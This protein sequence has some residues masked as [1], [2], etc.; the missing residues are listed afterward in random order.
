MN[1]PRKEFREKNLVE[2]EKKLNELFPSGIPKTKTWT[3]QAEIIEVLNKLGK[4][5]SLNHTFLPTGGGLDLAGARISREPGC[6]ELDWGD[7][8]NIIKPLKLTFE[9]FDADLE[10]A[11][12]RIECRP[13]AP[14]GVYDSTVY[15]SEEL[16]EVR[17]K[18]Y[19]HRSEWDERNLGYDENGKEIPL[20]KGARVV[21]RNFSGAFV[22]FAKGSL[23]NQNSGTYDARHN[24]MTED[25][26]R[27][28]I[29]G[30]IQ[31]L[32]EQASK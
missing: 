32:K 13:L 17:P 2:W 22:I 19:A 28:H 14:S 3:S 4:P 30:V 10:W 26:F 6:I 27:T 11:Y 9:S 15:Q 12:F 8:V 5:P 24:K 20:P 21:T 1:N 18:E 16:T 7:G 31:Y 25:E 23:Y 29:K